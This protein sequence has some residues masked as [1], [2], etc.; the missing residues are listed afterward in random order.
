M[1]RG[2]C[3]K[4]WCWHD[5]QRCHG[6]T[7][8]IATADVKMVDA[9]NYRELCT[10]LSLVFPPLFPELSSSLALY[11]VFFWWDGVPNH[12][13]KR[14]AMNLSCRLIHLIMQ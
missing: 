8:N 2:L 1:R 14:I 12:A 13:V 9:V 5:V 11:H 10:R 6:M 4:W 7:Q 3:V